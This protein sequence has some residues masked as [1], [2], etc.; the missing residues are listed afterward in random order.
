M[1]IGAKLIPGGNDALVLNG[2][3]V[4]SP[5]ALPVY[6]A[7]LA[8]IMVTIL[9]MRLWFGQGMRVDCS[10]DVCKSETRV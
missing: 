3:P 7:L 9:F 1:G 6:G 5:H 8:G 4:L 10:M 2:I